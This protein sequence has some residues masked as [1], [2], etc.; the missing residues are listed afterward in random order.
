M[1]SP[2]IALFTPVK[3]S[4]NLDNSDIIDMKAGELFSII[5]AKNRLTDSYEVLSFGNNIKGELGLG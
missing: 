3:I 1:N 2:M 4:K 5:V